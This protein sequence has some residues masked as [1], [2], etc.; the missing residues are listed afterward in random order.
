M[1]A[2]DF[3][4]LNDI[5]SKSVYNEKVEE[6]TVKPD[7]FRQIVS[8]TI[9]E[10][11]KDFTTQVINEQ[12]IAKQTALIKK[13]PVINERT[14][15]ENINVEKTLKEINKR[16][17]NLIRENVN[18]QSLIQEAKR[19][20]DEKISNANELNQNYARRILDLGGGGGSVAAQVIN[21]PTISPSIGFINALIFG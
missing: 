19:Y 15:T 14:V 2:R 17:D 6:K 8:K 3:N 5:Y 18:N 4:S 20:T 10:H 21:N 13:T 7:P 16:V 9:T 12:K 1:F 11:K